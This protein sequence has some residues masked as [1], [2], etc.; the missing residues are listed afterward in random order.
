M[1]ICL[2]RI[3]RNDKPGDGKLAFEG[4][5]YFHLPFRCDRA[6]VADELCGGCLDRRA[7]TERVVSA[8]EKEKKPITGHPT[9]LHGKVTEPIP[10][11]SHIYD[12]GWFRQQLNAG[13]VL[14]SE[15][16]ARAKKAAEK[17]QEGVGA[18][19]EPVAAPAAKRGRKKAAAAGTATAAEPA[20]APP[21]V[22]IPAEPATEIVTAAPP[23]AAPKRRQP[24]KTVAAAAA[25]QPAGPLLFVPPDSK[26]LPV[27][28]VVTIAVR[29]VTVGERNLYVDPK[30][31]KLY[32]LKFNYLGRWDRREDKVVSFPDSDAE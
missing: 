4:G 14:S 6:A 5:G 29:K 1:S 31:D 32:D 12:G 22:R 27:E 19:P 24:R 16:M 13:S 9:M 3:I 2:G 10:Y 17:T 7:R 28:E 26:E 8:Y 21:P 11:W 18:A 25:D 23:P 30:K 20:A 15:T